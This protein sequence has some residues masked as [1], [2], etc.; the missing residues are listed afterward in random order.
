VRRA[1]EYRE[2]LLRDRALVTRDWY[3]GWRGGD[4]R[5][6]RP[7]PV[8]L[9]GFPR[10]GTTLLDTML[11]GHPLVQVLEERPLI[12][13][14]E[15]ESGGLEKLPNLSADEIASLRNSYFDEAK[16][17]LDL[18]DDTLL[19]DKFPLH[20]NKVP[21]IHRLFPDAR[22]ILALRHPLDVLLSCYI[23]N[24]RLNNAM[25]NFLDLETAAW[26]YD[27]SFGFWEQSKSIM[28]V[29]CHTVVYE[30]MVENAGAELRPLFQYLD[31]DWTDDVLD[32][33]N[34]ATGRGVITTASYSQVTEPIYTRAKGRWSRYSTRLEPAI[35]TVQPWIER[36]GY[37]I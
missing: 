3:T 16:R 32:H 24:F 10:S 21:Y 33:Q 27:Q 26:V 34:T 1:R 28:G 8:F 9:L 15:R 14:V 23:T 29:K 4:A 2:A 37:Q 31:L 22:F 25:A 12:A 36:Y 17:W 18:R 11:M 35:P 5:D 13:R 7:A 19:V 6:A 20:L 30:R